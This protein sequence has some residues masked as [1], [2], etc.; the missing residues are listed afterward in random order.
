LDEV[1]N[2]MPESYYETIFV[3]RQP[4]FTVDQ[5]IWGYELLFRS[6]T[7]L[8]AAA[9][10]DADQATLQVIADGF[11][12]ATESVPAEARILINFPQNL[13]VGDAPYVL[14]AQRAIVEILE[15]VVPEPQVLAACQRLREAGYTLALDDFV[16]EPG[17]EPLCA[18]ADIVKVDILHQT[19]E[20]VM[21]VVKG[22]R[23]Y[24]A[25]L[26][27]EKVETREMF[28]ICKRLGF[29]YFQG[30]FFRK[31]EL[32]E[33]RKL[34][35]SQANR[36]RLLHELGQGA[37]M[38]QLVRILEADVSLSYR[39]LR[40]INSVR[41]ALVKKVDS[42]QRAASMLGRKNLQHWLQVTL[43]ADMNAA[44]RAQELVRLSVVRARFF[45]LLAEAGKTPLD[46]DAMFLLGF[47]SLL[48]GILDQ[49]MEAI[50]KEI[51]IDPKVASILVDPNHPQ[52]LWLALARDIDR[53]YWNEVRQR[54]QDLGLTPGQV[55]TAY[56]EAS[57]WTDAMLG[58]DA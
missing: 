17:F 8:G 42:I 14:P 57:R 12:L 18:L 32:V 55:G 19:P 52:A 15:T 26:L 1:K 10:T 33:G 43:L 36:I 29:Q 24:R 49:P 51:P 20:K 35:A 5:R 34:S 6:K 41:F 21:A 58:T 4:I 3:A 28:E 50:L 7:D 47:F 9:I 44:P 37:D 27:A 45:Q 31:P 54:C 23:P 16:G 25:T 46:A 22:L 40:Y 39:L 30:Y 56:H 38:E 48:D 11:A 2:S 13:L 53:C